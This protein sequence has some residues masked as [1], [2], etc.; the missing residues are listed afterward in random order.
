MSNE[1]FSPSHHYESLNHFLCLSHCELAQLWD[2][3]MILLQ[4]VAMLSFVQHLAHSRTIYLCIC[5]YRPLFSAGNCNNERKRQDPC[6][7]RAHVLWGGP[8]RVIGQDHKAKTDLNSG[9]TPRFFWVL[10]NTQHSAKQWSVQV[11]M[12]HHLFLKILHSY[13][14]ISFLSLQNKYPFRHQL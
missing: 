12:H 10:K 5:L 4:H 1:K 13:N 9:L 3:T 8:G 11:H 7:L 6:F 14:C 2:E